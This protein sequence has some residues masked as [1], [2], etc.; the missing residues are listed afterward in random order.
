M[1]I[2]IIAGSTDWGTCQIYPAG[3]NYPNINGKFSAAGKT[4]EKPATIGSPR[5]IE[6]KNR[7][8]N[9]KRTKM[10]LRIENPHF[11][12]PQ[13]SWPPTDDVHFGPVCRIGW[14]PQRLWNPY[15]IHMKSINPYEIHGND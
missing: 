3:Y 12:P 10:P 13:L 7:R 11:I 5:R 14:F 6:Q 4:C 9:G 2:Y 15:E 1:Y 8:Q